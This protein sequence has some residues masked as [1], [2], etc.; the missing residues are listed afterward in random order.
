MMGRKPRKPAEPR[1]EPPKPAAHK[2]AEP[3]AKPAPPQPELDTLKARIRELEAEL[4]RYQKV[5]PRPLPETLEALKAERLKHEAKAKARR[6]EEKAKHEAA[7]AKAA[8][9]TAEEERTVLEKLEQAE[10][11]L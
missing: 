9:M 8:A 7:K 10:K 3:E 2:P 5:Y 4:G 1:V 11:L 6:E